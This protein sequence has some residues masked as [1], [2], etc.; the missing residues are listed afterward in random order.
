MFKEYLELKAIK[1]HIKIV[2]PSAP[3]LLR[4]WR[5]P[6]PDNS[7]SPVIHETLFD[8]QFSNHAHNLFL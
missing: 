8:L 5:E 7:L 4:L 1:L 3:Y 6:R 2:L